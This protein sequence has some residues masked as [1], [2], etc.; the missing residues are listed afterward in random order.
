M[1]NGITERL[2]F[3]AETF[4]VFDT[5]QEAFEQKYN[6]LNNEGFEVEKIYYDEIIIALVSSKFNSKERL[7]K[8]ISVS[9]DVFSQMIASDPTPHKIYVQW[10]LNLFSRFLKNEKTINY[11]VRLV[12]EDLPIA[13]QYLIL[14]E[15]N[16]RKKKFKELSFS[17]YSLKG[18]SDPTDINQYKSLSQLFDAV[19]PF[20]EKDPS[21]IE[22]TIMKYVEANKAIIPVKDRKFTVY[23]PLTVEASTV[24]S[25]YA[26]WCT[27][28]VGNGMFKNYTE[29]YKQP[30]GNHSKLYIIINND[31]F[32][33]LSDEL[34]Q[35]HFE[36]NQL[37]ARNNSD[38]VDFYS[39]VLEKSEGLSNYFK[40]EL[41]LMA[42]HKKTIKN[43]LY[44][45]Y[46][47]KF[48]FAETLFDL[49]ETDSPVIKFMD[50]KIPK[51]PNLN[52]FNKL[53][54]III[55][56]ADLKELHPSI[57][58]LN[59]LQMLVLTNNRLTELPNNIGDLKNLEF[60]NIKGNYIV[61]IPN[62]ISK[63][64][65]SNGGSLFRIVVEREEIGEENYTKLKKLL[66][67]TNFS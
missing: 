17:S 38:N 9:S 39:K 60:L 55:T 32:N 27:A 22:R 47:L 61:D 37:K 58:G 57:C 36:T 10:M 34:F 16:K 63:L 11:G 19:D 26:S 64:D 14:F 59:N 52:G 13:N 45:N 23:I 2:I 28:R 66:P 54:Q 67:T 8:K 20:I 1:K 49:L 41:S 48:G 15:E 65:K 53:E 62:S 33:N 29:N 51:I 6:E 50:T 7:I 21:V 24:F 31:F 42:K 18:V 30:N 5:S 56:G 43:N 4:D 12:G 46:L 44:L 35:I 25:Q 3:L 40:E